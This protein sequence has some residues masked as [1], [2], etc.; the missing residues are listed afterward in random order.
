MLN[1]RAYL[2]STLLIQGF[3]VKWLHKSVMSKY[4]GMRQKGSGMKVGHLFFLEDSR[5][6]TSMLSPYIPFLLHLF[7]LHLEPLFLASA[8]PWQC[9]SPQMVFSLAFYQRASGS[10]GVLQGFLP[11]I[12]SH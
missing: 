5:L 12:Y 8:S 10:L 2:Y 11:Q 4:L 1:F 9:R 3:R 6:V 7:A